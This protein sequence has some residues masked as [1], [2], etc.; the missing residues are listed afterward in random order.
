MCNDYD[1]EK[2]LPLVSTRR[3]TKQIRFCKTKI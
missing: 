3:K 1:D 2:F